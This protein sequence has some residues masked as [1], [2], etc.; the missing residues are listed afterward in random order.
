[1]GLILPDFNAM[2]RALMIKALW[3]WWTNRYIAKWK[4]KKS[5]NRPVQ[6]D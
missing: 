4:S 2:Y 5:K 6:K 1:M 3:Y